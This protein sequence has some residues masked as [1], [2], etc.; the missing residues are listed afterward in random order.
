MQQFPLFSLLTSIV[1]GVD[2]TRANHGQP[3][4]F[5]SPFFFTKPQLQLDGTRRFTVLV[6][7][8][9]VSPVSFRLLTPHTMTQNNHIFVGP[10]L[11]SLRPYDPSDSFTYS[12]FNIYSTGGGGFLLAFT[13]LCRI[14][15]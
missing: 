8:D 4:S 12:S 14:S 5:L 11:R 6:N 1:R 7:C 3:Y 13:G 10:S 2:A 9:L 15:V